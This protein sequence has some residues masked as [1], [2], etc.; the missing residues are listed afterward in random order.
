MYK[1]KRSGPSTDPWGTPEVTRIS[2]EDSPSST[3]VWEWPIKKASIHFR[4]FPVMLKVGSLYSNFRWLTLSK[5]LLKS[6]RIKSVC[7]LKVSRLAKVY[8][9]IIGSNLNDI[10]VLVQHNVSDWHNLLNVKNKNTFEKSIYLSIYLS[11]SLS[12]LLPIYL[13]IYLNSRHKTLHF[14]ENFMTRAGVCKTLCP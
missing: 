4:V 11:I 13:S 8:A 14:A 2:L 1:R 3:T 9:D 12:Q 6:K 5:A 7:F 10:C